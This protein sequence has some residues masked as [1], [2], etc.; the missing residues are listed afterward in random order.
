MGLTAMVFMSV[1]FCLISRVGVF[2]YVL[3]VF[4]NYGCG[5]RQK[6]ILAI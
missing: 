2:Y 3:K 1:I 5:L 6:G 4:L